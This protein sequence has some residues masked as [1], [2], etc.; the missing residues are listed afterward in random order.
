MCIANVRNA[1]R[2]PRG[3]TGPGVLT[4]AV[5]DYLAREPDAVATAMLYPG[6]AGILLGGNFRASYKGSVRAWQTGLA[7][8]RAQQTEG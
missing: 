5:L 1:I 3:A 8:A 6:E 2:D 4:K 7:Q